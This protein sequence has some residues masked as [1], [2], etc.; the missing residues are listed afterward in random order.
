V[1]WLFSSVWWLRSIAVVVV[2]G[3]VFLSAAFAVN[4]IPTV[5]GPVVPQAVVPGSGA[6]TLKVYGANFVSGAVVNWNRSP[7]TT[8]FISARELD[9]QILA[10][11]VAKPTAGYITVTNPPPSGGVSSSSYS[12]VEVHKPTKTIAVKAPDVLPSDPFYAI[13]ADVDGDGKLDLVTGVGSGPVTLNRGNGD[14]TFQPATIIGHSYF[15]GAGITFGDFNN[16][17]KLD[18]LYGVGPCCDPPT[19]LKVLIGEGKDKFSGLPRFDLFSDSH[20]RGIVAADFNGD[21]VLDVAVSR[22][23]GNFGG[24]IFLGRGDGTFEHVQSLVRGYGDAVVADFNGDG[25]LDVVVSGGGALYLF[26]GNGDGTFQKARR[27]ATAVVGCAYGPSLV[28]NDFNRDGNPDLAFCVQSTSNAS[29]IGVMLGNGDGTFQRPVYYPTSLGA[30][31]AFSF[32]AGDFNSDGNTD[33]IAS[34]PVGAADANTTNFKQEFAVLWGNGDGTFQKARKIVLPQNG[35]GEIGI[36]QGDFNSDGLLDFVLAGN[37]GL[38]VYIE[39]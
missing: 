20:A 1:N 34:T 29:R 15:A 23:G 5:V 38:T 31:N 9:A 17:G 30:G 36:V 19:Y 14:G 3:F 8:T 32:T 11:D 21:G 6:F 26:L 18:L 35:G 25:R 39:K 2:C 28:V 16:D 24:G 22:E 4:P 33:L 10:T 37:G 7:R 13:T 12:L 27:I